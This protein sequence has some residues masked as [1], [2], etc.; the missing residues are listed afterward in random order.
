MSELLAL[1]LNIYYGWPFDFIFRYDL[2]MNFGGGP[3]E[4]KG[5]YWSKIQ[6]KCD[7]KEDKLGFKM[8]PQGH[9]YLIRIQYT[10][11]STVQYIIK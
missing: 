4:A 11:Y 5:T 7:V 2:C 6:H 10:V 3:R 9:P 1:L 8:V